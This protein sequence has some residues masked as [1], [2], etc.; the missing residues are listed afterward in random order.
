MYDKF[1]LINKSMNILETK[2]KKVEIKKIINKLTEFGNQK[3]KKSFTD[4]E[5]W[6]L[7]ESQKNGN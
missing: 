6:N 7:M 2:E 4:S 5:D 3:R 1:V